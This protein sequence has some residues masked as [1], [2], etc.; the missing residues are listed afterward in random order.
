[1]RGTVSDIAP[2]SFEETSATYPRHWPRFSGV[3]VDEGDALG[4]AEGDALAGGRAVPGEGEGGAGL[5]DGGGGVRQGGQPGG[6]D[7]CPC[8]SA[9]HG[10]PGAPTCPSPHRQRERRVELVGSYG[11]RK[12][13]AFKQ[14]HPPDATR[15]CHNCRLPYSAMLQSPGVRR[16]GCAS[17][18]PISLSLSLSL[19]VSL[20]PSDAVGARA[21]NRRWRRVWRASPARSA[22]SRP[23]PRSWAP[24]WAS[25][26]LVSTSRYASLSSSAHE[27]LGEQ[28]GSWPGY[29]TFA[30]FHSTGEKPESTLPQRRTKRA[31]RCGPQVVSKVQEYQQKKDTGAPAPPAAETS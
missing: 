9:R 1:V 3:Q 29:N 24:R 7:L 30:P 25:R 19:S 6:A 15:R 22:S 14:N 4:D 8:H 16:H 2:W 13:P 5:E 20:S 23:R 31:Q 21:I 28:E 18:D 12:R 11:T 17:T 10:E 26:S 27:S